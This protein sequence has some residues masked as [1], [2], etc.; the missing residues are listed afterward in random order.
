MEHVGDIISTD[1]VMGM[2]MLVSV[3]YTGWTC[4]SNGFRSKGIKTKTALL[5]LDIII[6]ITIIVL[7]TINGDSSI[8][9]VWATLGVLSFIRMLYMRDTKRSSSRNTTKKN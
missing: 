9:M 3:F 8:Q 4:W 7:A 6:S 5:T 2:L 1:S